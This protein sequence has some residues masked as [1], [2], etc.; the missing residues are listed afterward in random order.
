MTTSSFP[1]FVEGQTL[2][3]SELNDLRTF[4]DDKD[5]ALGRMIGFGV[6]CG[7]D[8]V[9]DGGNYVISPGLAVDQLGRPIIVSEEMTIPVTEPRSEFDWLDPDGGRQTLVLR[10]EETVA[11]APDCEEDGCRR[12]ASL[13]TRR[14]VLAVADGCLE[15]GSFTVEGSELSSVNPITVSKGS[16]PVNTGALL[17]GAISR[18]LDRR[19]F[20]G[21]TVAKVTGAVIAPSDLAGAATWKAS[22]LN[23]LYFATLELLRCEALT[24]LACD[25]STTTPG[26]ALG[27]NSAGRWDCNRRHHWEPPAGLATTLLGADCED[28]CRFHRLRIQ[29]I[30]DAFVLPEFPKPDDPPKGGGGGP[31]KVC[32]HVRYKGYTEI[33]NDLLRNKGRCSHW[34]APPLVIEDY[35]DK[36]DFD[37]E[38]FVDIPREA[39]EI[40][41][42]YGGYID[43][44]EVGT[45]SLGLAIGADPR[46]VETAIGAA[47]ATS[48]GPDFPLDVQIVSSSEVNGIDGYE[49]AM[50][51]AITDTLVLVQDSMGKVVATGRVPVDR[52]LNSVGPSVKA[53]EGQAVAAATVADEAITKSG[54]LEATMTTTIAELG[55]VRGTVNDHQ[56]LLKGAGDSGGLLAIVDD[57]QGK[58]QAFD[59]SVTTGLLDASIEA[60]EQ[61]FT[62]RL[63]EFDVEIQNRMVAEQKDFRLEMEARW[64]RNNDRIDNVLIES[65]FVGT[66]SPGL[67]ADVVR[68]ELVETFKALAGA[69]AEM[70][71][72][73]PATLRTLRRVQQGIG[74]MEAAIQVGSGSGGTAGPEIVA[75]FEAMAELTEGLG[76][77]RA[78]VRNLKNRVS[79]LKAVYEQ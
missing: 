36:F 4:L 52:T 73:D 35:R 26:V 79:A 6:N 71:D 19:G 65:K 39:L 42:V 78:T 49:P 28:P 41:E 68:P 77:P 30:I 5:H 32:K 56:D 48:E 60:T 54:E 12:H 14:P 45:L 61:K 50:D 17:S 11:E 44:L 75:A 1:I 31:W 33:R 9:I 74:R 27:C 15:P 21:E 58:V 67:D 38:I 24:T 40:G 23:Q 51:A 53:V 13:A 66:R 64:E 72:G 59:G 34:T 57:L 16:K 47:V 25:R 69:V 3:E 2:T 18:V 43:P 62:T 46:E 37:D 10:L 63:A 55:T 7:L 22:F 76:A 29:A 8:V 70:G 20:S